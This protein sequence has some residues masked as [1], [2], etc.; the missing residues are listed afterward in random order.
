MGLLL[1]LGAFYLLCRFA[2]FGMHGMTQWPNFLAV[3]GLVILLAAIVLELKWMS[4]AAAFGY[5]IGFGL[6]AVFNTD[7][8][9]PGGGTTNDLW[10]IWAA[11]YL[12][13]VLIGLV[14]DVVKKRTG[15]QNN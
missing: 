7:G 2:F 6:G 3:I 10:I 12:V 11:A 5:I 4:I 13:C 9:D 1:C 8:L 14:V 15:K